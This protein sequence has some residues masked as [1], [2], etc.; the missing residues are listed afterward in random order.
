MLLTVVVILEPQPAD[1]Q[2]MTVRLIALLSD[3]VE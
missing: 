1:G 2:R 3:F